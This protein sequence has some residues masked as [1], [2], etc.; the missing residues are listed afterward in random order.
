MRGNLIR[1]ETTQ[2]YADS[3]QR[4]SERIST[5][6][7]IEAPDTQETKQARIITEPP[8][9][10][11]HT[12]PELNDSTRHVHPAAHMTS[13]PEFNAQSSELLGMTSPPLGDTAMTHMRSQDVPRDMEAENLLEDDV[14]TQAAILLQQSL[15]ERSS[16]IRREG[17]RTRFSTCPT[18]TLCP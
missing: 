3:F 9:P 1:T 18:Q 12:D 14:L 13:T 4:F 11:T 5:V 15:A 2:V 8:S 6:L 7:G 10:Q 17:M 16:P